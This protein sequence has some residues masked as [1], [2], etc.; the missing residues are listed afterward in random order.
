MADLVD[1]RLIFWYAWSMSAV[2]SPRPIATMVHYSGRMKGTDN[3]D[4][5][6]WS[7]MKSREVSLGQ[8]WQLTEWQ[9]VTAYRKSSALFEIIL[10][11]GIFSSRHVCAWSSKVSFDLFD[12][13]H[14]H[15]QILTPFGQGET[16][17]WQGIILKLHTTLSKLWIFGSVLRIK[18]RDFKLS[19]KT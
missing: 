19:W 10:K 13:Y 15:L 14:I 9:Q 1:E 3:I 2:Q 6:T 5:E 7:D 8:V 18:A 16:R 11:M 17:F 4:T 12:K